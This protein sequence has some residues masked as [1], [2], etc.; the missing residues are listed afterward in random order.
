MI[1]LKLFAI[2]MTLTGSGNSMAAP[3]EERSRIVHGYLSPPYSATA[4]LSTRKRGAIRVSTMEKR[5]PPHSQNDPG[6]ASSFNQSS[7]SRTS[8]EIS[9]SLHDG[10]GAPS[11]R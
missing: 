4:R 10:G 9:R 8:R 1:K 6:V 5:A 7:A 3:V 2:G 11:D